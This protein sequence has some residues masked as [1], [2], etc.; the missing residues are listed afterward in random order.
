MLTEMLDHDPVPKEEDEVLINLDRLIH[1]FRSRLDR[2]FKTLIPFQNPEFRD[3]LVKGAIAELSE[4][5]LEQ[6]VERCSSS[7]APTV[8][9]TIN[10]Q[11]TT[12]LLNRGAVIAEGVATVCSTLTVSGEFHNEPA[13]EIEMDEETSDF[14]HLDDLDLPPVEECEGDDVRRPGI[15]TGFTGGLTLPYRSTENNERF[16][17]NR[18]PIDPINGK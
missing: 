11:D 15:T 18:Q 13:N 5:I 4:A 7:T 14:R 3:S 9:P 8:R 16:G 2:S 12:M 17:D 6:D 10:Y 1:S